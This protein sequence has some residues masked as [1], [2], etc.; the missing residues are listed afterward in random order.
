MK[1]P[2]K[3]TDTDLMALATAFR[4]ARQIADSEERKAAQRSF[5]KDFVEPILAKPLD[6]KKTVQA[7]TAN[8]EDI[9]ADPAQFQRWKRAEDWFK[10]LLTFKHGPREASR[11]ME[12]YSEGKLH[13]TLDEALELRQEF[14][15]LKPQLTK[16]QK[17][18]K[19]GSVRAPGKDK[20][21]APRPSAIPEVGKH[22][23]A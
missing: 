22:L 4:E 13:L 14:I 18:G 2:T 11:M 6:Y 8:G 9:A 17:K 1:S 19:Q 5:E 16:T 20:R 12:K 21:L 7:I 3:I 10:R 15:D 23:T